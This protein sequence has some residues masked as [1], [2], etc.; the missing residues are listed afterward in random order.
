MVGPQDHV[1]D[2]DLPL[3]DEFNRHD[4]PRPMNWYQWRRD[5]GFRIPPPPMETLCVGASPARM[6]GTVIV[7]PHQAYLVAA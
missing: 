2:V 4:E 3:N 5:H 6:A 1:D 7:G